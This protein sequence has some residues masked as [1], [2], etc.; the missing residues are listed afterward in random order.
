MTDMKQNPANILI[1]DDTPDNLRLLTGM[2]L[3]RG[4]K[5]RPVPN[6]ALALQ[7]ARTEPP[8]MILLDIHM[9]GM[10]GYEVCRQLKRD[11]TLKDIPVIFIS[12]LNETLDKVK[13][14]S[15]GGVDYVTK[16]FQ[17][18]EVAARV[19]TH[20]I[21]RELQ[22]ELQKQNLNLENLVAQRTRE[23]EDAFTRL[24]RLDQIKS[25]FLGMISHEVRTP[26]NGILNLA[27]FA[28]DLAPASAERNELW[29]L[30]E[31]SRHRMD[32]LL[33]DAAMLD[34]LESTRLERS[35]AR[36]PVTQTLLEAQQAVPSIHIRVDF[37][38]SFS[39]VC[40]PG[41]GALLKRAFETLIRLAA[42]FAVTRDT[43][44]LSGSV[45]QGQV[46]LRFALDNLRVSEKE[47]NDFFNIAS[48]SR[49]ASY[50]E[51]L[52]LAPV[53]AHRIIAFLGGDVRLVKQNAT[54]GALQI[55]LPLS[56]FGNADS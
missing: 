45:E 51:Q 1:V 25:D 20:L 50:A 26:L 8:D 52:G 40:V 17:F 30:Y 3:E 23:L 27:E 24:K 12:A 2:L 32:R 36:I 34:S 43:V 11:A 5:P 44:S 28:F 49:S 55:E 9:P 39:E 4:Y 47:A 42:C 22:R 6:G 21:L 18:E 35:L 10:D 53:V 31:G 41:E 14:F 13:A 56:E 33:D 16:P 54:T 37:P 19:N 29:K 7:A 46:H 15:A 38:S 48:P